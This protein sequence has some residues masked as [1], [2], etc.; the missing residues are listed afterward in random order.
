MFYSA[1][2]V[3]V[4]GRGLKASGHYNAEDVFVA[5]LI[6]KR[7]GQPV[8][9]MNILLTLDCFLFLDSFAMFTLAQRHLVSK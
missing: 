8:V 2:F 7:F 5:E 9:F 4:F 3:G 1:E 6:W